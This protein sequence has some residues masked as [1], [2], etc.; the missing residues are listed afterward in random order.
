MSSRSA[1]L[2]IGDEM[3]LLDGLR[4]GDERA[5][6]A[7][8]DAYTPT[9]LRVAGGYV[10]DRAVAEEVVQ[11][12][13]L[14]V[15]NGI[16][17]FRGRS[18][19]KTWIFKILTNTA[20]SHGARERRT[21]PFSSLSAGRE[22]ADEPSVDPER[23]FPSDHPRYP[24]HWWLGPADWQTPEEGLLAGETRR[25]ILEAIDQLPAPQR[26]AVTLRD[27]EGWSAKEVAEV[28]ETTEGNQRVLLHRGRTKVRA[29]LERELGA[30]RE[31]VAPD[32]TPA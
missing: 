24:N 25:V 8:C 13:W 6:T 16:E 28:L 30:V 3:A 11:E 22:E 32:D 20:A 12:T 1:S 15:L 7:L 14:G 26:I 21:V 23:F 17:R 18:S 19:L 4:A 2:A 9:L 31:T 29:A 27:I 10:R 5:F